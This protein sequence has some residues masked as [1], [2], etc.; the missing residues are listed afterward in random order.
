ME[1]QIHCCDRRQ[2]SA[3]AVR[4]LSCHASSC[5]AERNWSAWGRLYTSNRNR[6]G[7]AMAEKL[8]F[9]KANLADDQD[10]DGETEMTEIL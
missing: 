2:F 9:I 8:L 3:A 7:K 10:E 6:L 5:A 4:L 1:Q